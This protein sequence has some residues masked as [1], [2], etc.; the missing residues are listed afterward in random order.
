MASDANVKILNIRPQFYQGM[1][2]D[3]GLYHVEVSASGHE[4][5]KEWV[6]LGT[7]EHR[8]LIVRLR[9][10]SQPGASIGG[11]VDTFTVNGVSFKMVRIPAGEFMMGS[12][13]NEPDRDGD[14]TQH[15]VRISRDFWMGE[16]EVTQGLWKSVMGVSP[17]YFSNCGDDCPVEKVSWDDCQ[18]F[19]RKLNGMVVS[20]GNFRL[21]TEAEWEYACRAGT[22]AAYSG[23]LDVMGWYG[24]NSGYRII[25]AWAI[26]IGLNDDTTKYM[27]KL[28]DNGCRIHSV[29]DMES[30]GWRLYDM[31]GNV[32]EWCQD[33]YGEYSTGFLIDPTG[34]TR[35]P[36]R[37]LRGGCRSTPARF[38]RSAIRDRGSPDEFGS[39]IGLRLAKDH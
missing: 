39:V 7:D 5:C 27:E 38:C 4:T 13:L 2:L 21:P 6:D 19:I 23:D 24:N 30:N 32:L 36:E 12:P 22:T 11:A 35:G 9:T 29:A 33:W 14:E 3:P 25:D 1:E 37:V 28:E 26:R 31:H 20:G 17:S 15:R 18:E 8:N 34:P 16:T 10:V